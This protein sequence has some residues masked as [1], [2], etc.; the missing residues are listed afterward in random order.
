[1]AN[2]TIIK[3]NG[4]T[5]IDS[6]EV[7]DLIGKRHYDL[8]RDIG[9][10]CKYMEIITERK[11][12]VSD[13]FIS[14]SYTDNSGR[15]LPCI[16]LSKMGCEMVANKLTGE[17]GILF[18]AA[19]VTKFNEMEANE[20]ANQ[21]S[22]AVMLTPRLGE[23]NACARI[24]IRVLREIG[25]MPEDM[26]LFLKE[27]Y[28]PLGVSITINTEM[29]L[30]EKPSV[31]RMYTA[32]QIAETLGIYSISGNPH[33]QA[34]SCILNE[35]LFISDK[36]KTVVTFDAGNHVG[37]SIQYDN[38]AVESVKKWLIEYALPDKVY[39]FSRTYSIRYDQ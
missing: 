27:L 38:Y 12:A 18:T 29:D 2:L 5:Y 4:G 9:R 23:Y 10:Y 35:N 34:I 30:D 25:A 19:Y 3:Q 11:I 37:I 16:L 20:R 6:R 14:S 1:M 32:K 31:P 26:I 15:T 24:V 28:S 22:R 21:E 13:F 36:H 17:K 39:G 7:A 8:L 33:A